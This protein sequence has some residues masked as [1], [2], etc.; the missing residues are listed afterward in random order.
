MLNTAWP[1]RLAS[2]FSTQ[3]FF[4]AERGAAFA[5]PQLFGSPD[6]LLT[7]QACIAF[8]SHGQTLWS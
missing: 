3:P 5:N 6:E 8:D 2:A 4:T 1:G 7:A